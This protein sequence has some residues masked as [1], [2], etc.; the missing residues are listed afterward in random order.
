MCTQYV[1]FL[2]RWQLKYTRK[3]EPQC[4]PAKDQLVDSRE[5]FIAN[6]PKLFKS[7][8]D[9]FVLKLKDVPIFMTLLWHII[10]YK[11]QSPQ[12]RFRERF[13]QLM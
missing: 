8:W 7:G 13:I 1:K 10:V 6:F 3:D 5:N 12:I 2:K 11:L 4:L 9:N